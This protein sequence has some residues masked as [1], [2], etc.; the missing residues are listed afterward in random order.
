MLLINAVRIPA[1]SVPVWYTD[2][3][4]PDALATPF[5]ILSK[6]EDEEILAHERCHVKQMNKFGS[7]GFFFINAYYLAKY[8]YYDNPFEIQAYNNCKEEYDRV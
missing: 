2:K 1:E 6:H 7:V 5:F 8:G 4:T 3:I